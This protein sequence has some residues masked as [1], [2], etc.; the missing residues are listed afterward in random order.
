[1]ACFSLLH[2]L[3]W[4]INY[5]FIASVRLSS[6]GRLQEVAKQDVCD[7]SFSSSYQTAKCMCNLLVSFITFSVKTFTAE[8][9]TR[10]T[11][12]AMLNSK[13]HV[14][15]APWCVY[16]KTH[17]N[18]FIGIRLDQAMLQLLL[19]QCCKVGGVVYVF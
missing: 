7:S 11:L 2:T 5:C 6:Y 19:L 13:R 16:R 18:C 12:V 4:E 17:H 3:C 15:D 14:I 10:P 9:Q 8:T 1:M